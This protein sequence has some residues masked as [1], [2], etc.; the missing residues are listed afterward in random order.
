M[1]FTHIYIQQRPCVLYGSGDGLCWCNSQSGLAVFIVERLI[2]NATLGGNRLS[3][4]H[5][6][7]LHR[8]LIIILF[9]VLLII[10][11]IKWRAISCEMRYTKLPFKFFAVIQNM[12]SAILFFYVAFELFCELLVALISFRLISAQSNDGR[13]V[14]IFSLPWIRYVSVVIHFGDFRFNSNYI[15]KIYPKYINVS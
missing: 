13:D 8:T 4:F 15:S 6:I 5:S 1:A 12:L 14:Q 3:I 2:G 7:N 10:I 9:H 11:R